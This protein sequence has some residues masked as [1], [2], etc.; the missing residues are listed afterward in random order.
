MLIFYIF[1]KG[2]GGEKEEKG[3]ETKNMHFSG[4]YRIKERAE[5][6]LIFF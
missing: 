1:F 6:I 3:G 4:Q 5:K 2:K